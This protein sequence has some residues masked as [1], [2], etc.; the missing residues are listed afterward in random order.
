MKES[1][2]TVKKGNTESERALIR[3]DKILSKHFRKSVLIHIRGP[4]QY[5]SVFLEK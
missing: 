4:R 5:Y 3:I 2:L 1:V